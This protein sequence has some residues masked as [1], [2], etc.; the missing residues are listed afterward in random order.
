MSRSKTPYVSAFKRLGWLVR[1]PIGYKT[2]VSP[3]RLQYRQ[4]LFSHVKYGGSIA[5]FEAAKTFRDHNRFS[6][7]IYNDRS[8]SANNGRLVSQKIRKRGADLPVCITDVEQFRKHGN[9]ITQSIAVQVMINNNSRTKSFCYG[10]SRTREEAVV[11]AKMALE[12][13]LEEIEQ[14]LAEGM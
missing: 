8:P 4:Q 14:D 11:L 1:V 9:A 12:R 10:H 6:G 3:K 7:L 5:S 2:G 13:F